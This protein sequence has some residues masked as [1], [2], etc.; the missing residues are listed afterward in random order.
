MGG[1]DL[2]ERMRKWI[3]DASP[4]HDCFTMMEEA[5]KEIEELEKRWGAAFDLIPNYRPRSNVPT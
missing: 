1:D 4:D 2:K 5:L 3:E